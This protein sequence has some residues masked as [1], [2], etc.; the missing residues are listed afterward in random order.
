M[1]FTWLTFETNHREIH[2]QLYQQNN[3]PLQ[4]QNSAPL[5][6]R[7]IPIHRYLSITPLTTARAYS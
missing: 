6:Q 7:Q 2:I 4:Y 1:P 3:A 5:H